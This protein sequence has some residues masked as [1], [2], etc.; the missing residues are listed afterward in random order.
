MPERP[1]SIVAYPVALL[2]M[3]MPKTDVPKMVRRVAVNLYTMEYYCL[4]TRR[5]YRSR[6]ES[7]EYPIVLRRQSIPPVRNR[8]FLAAGGLH[9]R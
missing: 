9:L 3:G 6:L 2:W 4:M 5:L 1:Y 7:A 8:K